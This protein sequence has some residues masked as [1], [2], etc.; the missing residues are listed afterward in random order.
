MRDCEDVLELSA[1]VIMKMSLQRELQANN[2][3]KQHT[4]VCIAD[5]LQHL[6]KFG[7]LQHRGTFFPNFP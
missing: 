3:P 6:F 4:S 1:G 2:N 5:L 7:F